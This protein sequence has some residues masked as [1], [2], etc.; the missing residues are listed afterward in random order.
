MKEEIIEIP[1]IKIEKIQI[2]VVGDTPLI[3]HAWSHKAKQEMLDKQMKKATKAKEAKDPEMDYYLSMYWLNDGIDKDTPKEVYREL[4]ESGKA[5][6]GFPSRAFKACAVDAAYQQKLIK[7]KTTARGAFHID[8]EFVEIF[9]TPTMREDTVTV[10]MG[11]ADLRYRG[12]FIEWRAVLDIKFNAATISPAQIV[13]MV[14]MGGFANGVG[15]W[16]PQKDGNC[17]RFHVATD[18]D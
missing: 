12:E 11:T 7:A 4:I 17:G 10:G 6:F 9:G 1:E 15:E 18:K 5:R 16:R 8:D 14:N 2:A 13:N 3:M